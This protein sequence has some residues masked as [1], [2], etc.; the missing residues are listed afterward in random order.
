MAV[1]VHGWT[2]PHVAHHAAEEPKKELDLAQTQHLHMVAMVAMGMLHKL[3]VVIMQTVLVR[4]QIICLLFRYCTCRVH[5]T[6]NPASVPA[7]MHWP[8]NQWTYNQIDT[9]PTRPT[10]HLTYGPVNPQ[11]ITPTTHNI[12]VNFFRDFFH[13]FLLFLTSLYC[14]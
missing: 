3:K 10:A 14:A 6:Y 9:Q 11:L 2:G 7:N 1:S 12:Y 5:Y 8:T 13:N 4:L